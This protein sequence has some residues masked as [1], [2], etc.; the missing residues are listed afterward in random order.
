[1]PDLHGLF[2]GGKDLPGDGAGVK[3]GNDP[4]SEGLEGCLVVVR[5]L[6]EH[7]VHKTLDEAFQGAENKC[8]EQKKSHRY[9]QASGGDEL[10]GDPAGHHHQHCVKAGQKGRQA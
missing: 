4:A 3:F 8:D 5:S 2:N 6:V 7:P 1:M 9:Q 10:F